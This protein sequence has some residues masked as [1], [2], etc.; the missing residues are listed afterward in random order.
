MKLPPSKPHPELD[1]LLA[2]VKD[3]PPM[4]KE[5]IEAQRKSWVIGEMMLSNLGMTREEAERIYNEALGAEY[6]KQV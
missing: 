6:K 2:K 3:M 5:Q 4:T 1:A